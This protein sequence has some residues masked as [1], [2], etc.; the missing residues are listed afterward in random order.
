MSAAPDAGTV[1]KNSTNQAACATKMLVIKRRATMRCWGWRATRSH[2]IAS[3]S[4]MIDQPKSP[5]DRSIVSK[6]DPA[7]AAK[8]NAPVMMTPKSS[9]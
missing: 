7:P 9:L 2:R 8:I 1:M 5:H 3:A 6:N 4:R